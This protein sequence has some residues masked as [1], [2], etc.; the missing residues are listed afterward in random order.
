MARLNKKEARQ[1]RHRR[2][3]RH[4]SG[5]AELPR[6]CVFCSDR[7][8]YAQVI[9]DEA[10]CTLASASTLDKDLRA[11]DIRGDVDG[12]AAIGKHVAEKALAANINRVVFDRGG[13]RFHGRVKA[14]AD[15]ARKAG[16]QF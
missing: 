16:L 14:V 11:T 10:E 15:G 6:L 1:R 5:S 7:H 2:I 8:V 4:L 13:F 9:D 3:R 12:A